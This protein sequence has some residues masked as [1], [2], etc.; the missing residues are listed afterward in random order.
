MTA[1]PGLSS[2]RFSWCCSCIINVWAACNS[3]SNHATRCASGKF[4]GGAFGGGV[5]VVVVVVVVVFSSVLVLISE[6]T[7][8]MLSAVGL[9]FSSFTSLLAGGR[10][11][12]IS[13][14]VSP[15]DWLLFGPSIDPS[16]FSSFIISVSLSTGA[17]SF[18]TATLL[19]SGSLCFCSSV[20]IE[21][22]FTD[23]AVAVAVDGGLTNE[24]KKSSVAVAV[25]VFVSITG[26][27]LSRWAR[28]CSPRKSLSVVVAAVVVVG[29]VSRSRSSPLLVGE[30]VLVSC[31][32]GGE[33]G[34]TAASGDGSED[35]VPSSLLA[36]PLPPPPPPKSNKS[37]DVLRFCFIVWGS[38]LALVSSTDC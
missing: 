10:A 32:A 7:L 31:G 9:V 34:T 35:D 18:P 23:M 6:S 21:V 8:F 15:C 36:S 28:G 16:F 26:A 1:S 30:F 19:A 27:K 22:S 25:V 17:E 29:V 14:I 24:L 5:V 3:F 13:T 38:V 20:F 4:S 33:L 2:S 37:T 12:G 11:G